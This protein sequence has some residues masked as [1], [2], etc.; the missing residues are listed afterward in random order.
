VQARPVEVKTT[1]KRVSGKELDQKGKTVRIPIAAR[2]K[3]KG[4]LHREKKKYS[5]KVKGTRG[6]E[7]EMS[8]K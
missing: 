2:N 6:G 7:F 1:E 5:R 3:K 8:L 4:N